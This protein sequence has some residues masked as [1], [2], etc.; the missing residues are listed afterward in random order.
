MLQGT[1][2]HVGY[3]EVRSRSIDVHHLE[4]LKR[5]LT[6]RPPQNGTTFT[7]FETSGKAYGYCF[8]PADFTMPISKGRWGHAHLRKDLM[9]VPESLSFETGKLPLVSIGIFLHC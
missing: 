7:A 9:L 8:N 3:A 1:Q 5:V 2:V 4:L 6:A